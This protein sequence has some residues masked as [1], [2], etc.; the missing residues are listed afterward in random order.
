MFSRIGPKGILFTN[1]F[2]ELEK[3]HL[4]L[5]FGPLGPSGLGSKGFV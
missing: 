2:H 4:G 1:I 3:P 5:G